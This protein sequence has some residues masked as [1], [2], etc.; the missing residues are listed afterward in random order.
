MSLPSSITPPIDL[1]KT[2]SLE[3]G[4]DQPLDRAKLMTMAQEFEAMLLLQMVRQMRQSLLMDEEE[5]TGLGNATMTDTFDTEFARY[6]SQTGGVG[7]ARFIEQQVA[8]TSAGQTATATDP[9]SA[10]VPERTGAALPAAQAAVLQSVQTAEIAKS[11]GLTPPLPLVTALSHQ[12]GEGGRGGE[13][14]ALS[15]DMPLDSAPTT[16]AYGW[17][18]DPF[19]G[20]RKFHNGVDLRAAYGTEVGAAGAG[21]VTHAGERGAYGMLVTIQHD[22]G[23]ETRYAHLSSATVAVG[24]RVE[25]GQGIGRVG[26]TGRSTAPHLHFEVLLDGQRV[27]PA[28]LVARANRPSPGVDADGGEQ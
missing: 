14:D 4:K 28:Q 5:D 25:A 8:K 26:S 12:G 10:P 24:D 1:T 21:T 2:F 15:L 16:S 18:N 9:A 23:L 17:R 20:R 19:K 6:L 22:N 27:D 3:A 13:G 11:A 7:L